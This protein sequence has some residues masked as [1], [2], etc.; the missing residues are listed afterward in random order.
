MIAPMTHDPSIHANA[1]ARCKRARR[2][3]SAFI[4]ASIGLA[5]STPAFAGGSKV[6][7]A[8]GP[9]GGTYRTVYGANLA[10]YIRGYEFF[11][12]DTSGSAENLR[13]LL[14]E[15]ADIAFVQAD[16]YAL[17][18]QRQ[19]AVAEG[20]QV[21]GR[22][23]DECVYVAYRR[24]GRVGSFEE[25]KA[26]SDEA[27]ARVAVGPPDGGPAGSWTWLSEV[28]P[29]LAA[30]EVD[31]QGGTLALNQLGVGR[32]D[33]VI[34]VTDP[35]NLNHIMLKTL[36]SNE[37]LGLLSLTDDALLAP[38]DDGTVVYQ[39]KKVKTKGGWSSKKLETICTSA[40]VLMRMDADPKLVD[41]VSDTIGLHREWIV[42]KEKRN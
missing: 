41:R 10:K 32:F 21:I 6:W 19:L 17:A 16:V 8:S 27:P 15:E 11:F 5:F 24:E 18:R 37:R 20:L 9:P 23:A 1:D 40:L 39:K 34:W 13:L 26:P 36:N 12:R 7:L 2:L 3:L 33:A 29:E 31:G 38:L 25:L 28:V 35:T 22:L 42:P 4:V 30:T 14:D